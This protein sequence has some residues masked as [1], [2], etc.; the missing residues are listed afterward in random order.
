MKR[1]ANE[2]TTPAASR[3]RAPLHLS[4]VLIA[5]DHREGLS[6]TRSRD[7]RSAVR[8]I[9]ALMGDNP[10]CIPLNLPAISAKLATTS[11]P[12][13]GMSA[14]RFSN[15][16][17]DFIAAVKES[18]LRSF[19]HAAKIPLSTEWR[20]FMAVLPTKRARYGLSRLSRYASARGIAPAKVD[21]AAIEGFISTVSN[22]TLH[23]K[24]NALHRSVSL[25]WNEVAHQSRLDLQRVDVPSFRRSVRRTERGQLAKSFR[26]DEDNFVKWCGGSDVFAK[27]ARPRP[28]ARQTINLR[29]NQ[30]HAAVTALVESGIEPGA[31]TSLAVLVSN[32]NFKRIMRQRY[33]MVG[34]RENVFNHDLGVALLQIAREWVHVKPAV[35]SELKRLLNMVPKPTPALTPK[36]KAALRQFDD[37]AVLRCLYGFSDRLWAEVKRDDKPN[38][39]TLVKAQVAI[40]VAILCYMP[41]RLQNLAALAFDQHLFLKQGPGAISS[42]E[43]SATEVKNKTEL[44]FDIPTHLAKMLIDYRNRI[45]PKVSGRR[46]D[47]LFVKVDGTRK[48]QWAVAWAIRK[49][50]KRRAGIVLSPHQFRHLSAKVILDREPGNFETPRQLLGHK[51]VQTTAA[52]YAG[53]STRRAARH[54]QQLVEEALAVPVATRRH[55]QS[56]SQH[57]VAEDFQ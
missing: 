33:E 32:E 54:H 6:A 1:K 44:A 24:P 30:I 46:P 19:S 15:V 40:G 28:L 31:I 52:I 43:L 8:R 42:L 49:Y 7:L 4:D 53:I 41:I 37:P 18:G 45:A 47:H 38:G 20:R 16:R 50:L 48:N 5:L 3:V 27:N 34:R 13:V 35:F 39:Q 29:R 51:S 36:N 56:R 23:R 11:P 10:A 22:E 55:K 2:R 14:K 25:I 9:S 21:H 57:A 12:S 26:K 17:S